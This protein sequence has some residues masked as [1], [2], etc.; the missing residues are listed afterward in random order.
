MKELMILKTEIF[1]AFILQMIERPGFDRFL[2]RIK[3]WGM[4]YQTFDIPEE[5]Y[6]QADVIT[7]REAFKLFKIVPSSDS[8]VRSG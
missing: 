2:L 8:L 7:P 3:Y 5:V 1:Q 6:N 4:E